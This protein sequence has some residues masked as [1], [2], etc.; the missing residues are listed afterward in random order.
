[1]PR[2]F[3]R[4]CLSLR[5]FVP[6]ISFALLLLLPSAGA[7]TPPVRKNVLVIIEVGNAHRAAASITESLLS[8]FSQN[9]EY[10]VE[11]YSENLDTPAFADEASQQR[12]EKLLVEEYQGRRIDVIVALGPRPIMFTSRF[13]GTFFPDVPV[14]FG[15]CTAQ[16]A[17]NPKLD[18]RFTGS[19]MKLEPAR[20]LDAVLTLLPKTQHLV[21]VNGSSAL[22]KG[23][24][25]EVRTVLSSHPETVDI[26]FFTDLTMTDLLERLR[27]LPSRTVILYSTFFRDAA[28]N[29][30]VN[31]TTT[32][33]GC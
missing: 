24:E 4:R 12:V 9:Q 31:A 23:V 7:A 32:L 3:S 14:V 16:Q 13:A 18:S 15:G 22:D 29:E 17:G 27:H 8:S 2:T 28:G 5:W 33:H 30:F 26:T 1:M 25:A 6:A 20:T 21:V 11:L 10:Q 19:W